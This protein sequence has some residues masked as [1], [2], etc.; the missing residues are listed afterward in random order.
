[1]KASE[2]NPFFTDTLVLSVE[3]ELNRDE[4]FELVTTKLVDHGLLTHSSK[5]LIIEKFKNREKTAVTAIGNGI[6][7]PHIKISGF[8]R[9]IGVF[10]K[11]THGVEWNAPDNEKVKLAIFIL[12]EEDGPDKNTQYLSTMAHIASVLHNDQ[13]R[14]QIFETD[15]SE[16]IVEL[17]AGTTTRQSFFTKYRSAVYFTIGMILITAFSFFLMS[18]VKLPSTNLELARFNTPYWIGRQV[19][20]MTLFFAMVLGTLLFF[21][22]RVAIAA[23]ALSILLSIGVES[24]ESATKAM[25]LPT[26][27]FIMGTMVI[28]RWL[29]SR[30]FFRFLVMS[31]IKRLGDKPFLLNASLLLFSAILAGLVD[32]VSAIIVMFQIAIEL[33]KIRKNSIIPYLIAIVMTTNIGS[34]LTL[35]GNPIGIYLAFSAKLTFINFL[36][37]TTPISLITLIVIT[38]FLLL[39]YWRNWKG[40]PI[41][42]KQMISEETISSWKDLSTPTLIFLLF[43]MLIVLHVPIEHIMGIGKQSTLLIAPLLTLAIIIFIEKENGKFLVERGPDWWTILYFMFLFAS[44]ACLEPTGVTDKFARLIETGAEHIPLSKIAVWG[45]TANAILLVLW[46]SALLS[47]FVDNL[48]IVAALV[49]VVQSLVTSGLPGAYLLWWALL[50]GA[51]FGGNLTMIGSTANLVAVGMYEKQFKAQFYF[52]DWIVTGSIVTFISLCVVSVCLILLLI[53]TV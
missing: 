33:A 53:M 34:A 39:Y 28:V 19:L 32:E 47:G 7:L 38:L 42:L 15:S 4:L 27:L 45:K 10:V 8:E 51:C 20:V 2:T 40:Q 22:Y 44:A 11:L 46:G 24:I 12:S 31:A 5:P 43:I 52:R 49:P 48:P 37:I 17:L 30:D 25:S 41:D 36:K 13:T 9:M 21:Q 18:T 14:K 1:M 35:I 3:D 26:I 29:E 16:K 23:F 50:I 6:A